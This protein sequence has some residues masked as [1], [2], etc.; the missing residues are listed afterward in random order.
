MYGEEGYYR[1]RIKDTCMT[2][3][4]IKGVIMIHTQK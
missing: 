4:R 3:L 1:L 2:D